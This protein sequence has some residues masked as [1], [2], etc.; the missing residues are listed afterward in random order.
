MADVFISYSRRDHAFVEQLRG[1]LEAAHREVWVDLRDI[2]PSAEW[3]DE[4]QRAIASSNAIICV[5][6]PDY[7]ASPICRQEV[8]YA[9]ANS[10]RLIPIVASDIA[11]HQA[12]P[13][14]AMLNWIFFR[15]SD[16]R[17]Q[18]MRQLLLALDSDLP[19]LRS[20]TRLLVRAKEWESKSRN[21][22]FTLR[23]KDLA[24]AEQWLATSGGKQPAPS[25]EQTQYIVASRRAS[26]SRQR[27]TIGALTIGILITLVL[28][29]ISTALYRVTSDQNV[30]LQG[31]S[32]AGAANDAIANGHLDQGLLLAV[33]ASKQH[34]DFDTRNAL[35]NGLDRASYLSAV[36]VGT[37]SKSS[38]ERSNYSEALYADDGQTLMTLDNAHGTVY[39]WNA[40]INQ[41][42]R[43]IQVPRQ[44][45]A[46]VDDF[47]SDAAISSDGKLLVTKSTVSGVRAHDVRNNKDLGILADMTSGDDT[48]DSSF[49]FASIRFSPNN[50][51]LAW[52]ECGDSKCLTERVAVLNIDT[53][54]FDYYP[55]VER[56]PYESSVTLAFS[57]D[58]SKLAVGVLD[59]GRYLNQQL[60]GVVQ[61]LDL[62]T[63]SFTATI[64]LGDNPA[65][66]PV[67]DVLALAFT[68]DGAELA[69]AG[70]RDSDANVGQVLFWDVAQGQFTTNPLIESD[71][72]I[73]ALAFSPDG[74]FLVTGCGSGSFGLRIWNMDRHTT[75]S[76]ILKQHT[77]AVNSI[78]FSPDGRHFV[79]GGADGQVLI[80]SDAPYTGLSHLFGDG[81]T[82]YSE[83][84]FSPDGRLLAI[85]S[86]N[87]VTLWDAKSQA[88]IKALS[89][90]PEYRNNTLDYVGGL[91][92][93]PDG[94]TIV[95][96]DQLAQIFV[97]SVATGALAGPPLH[98]HSP[99][100]PGTV[101]GFVTDLTFSP[102]GKWL[103]STALDYTVVLWDTSTWSRVY[104]FPDDSSG[105]RS[106][107]FSPDGQYITVTGGNEGILV[108]DSVSHTFARNLDVGGAI[109][110][111]L[112]FYPHQPTT[113]AALDTTGKITTWDVSSGK[114][115]GQSVNDGKLADT[116][117]QPHLLFNR[118][119]TLLISSHDLTLTIWSVSQ[120]GHL[121]QYVRSLVPEY[122]Q[123]NASI[124][125]DSRY[126]AIADG[127]NVEVRY[128]TLADWRA[129]AC[130]VANR[131][132]SR[133]EWQQFA[134]DLPYQ[135]VC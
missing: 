38:S 134:P 36:L 54:T 8:D 116:S 101:F 79:S 118:A 29:I 77:E 52:T 26:N 18:S 103:A 123:L 130:S 64:H 42:I 131:N 3:M 19:Y 33:A 12:P 110:K 7:V 83:T 35:L 17:D 96:G 46:G 53:E 30:V 84:A 13:A 9:V 39:L 93:S 11:G 48:R 49:T 21:A 97:W 119:G 44:D 56:S 71:G 109:M 107:A 32:I 65:S 72:E 121:Q 106:V 111:S 129:S 69:I 27:T 61:I 1:A 104:T 14:L 50:N 102:N 124:S 86:A 58:S 125:P 25:Q 57:P 55:L 4:I 113:L 108:W 85:G 126:I 100:I 115:I 5:L 6:S 91:A 98:G 75:V 51:L 82:N 76:P 80:W 89:I 34:D 114:Q 78:S 41:L 73:T 68:P 90:P 16:A 70:S 62:K 22:S 60:G 67:G 132:L 20:G 47:V 94:K 88:K 28:S 63:K 105:Q 40:A 117:Y 92:F 95:A 10:K 2:P 87:T 45:S 43:T 66:G 24:E 23:G 112:A 135:T 120:A 15:E 59:N 128:L 122:A 133:T 81:V 31:H 127:G 74:R 99:L 37:G